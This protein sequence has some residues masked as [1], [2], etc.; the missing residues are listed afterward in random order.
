MPKDG[1]WLSV[2]WIAITACIGIAA[3]A[4]G[5]Q[6]WL[7]IECSRIERWM[8]VVCGLLLVYPAP[9]SDAIGLAGVAAVVTLQVLRRRRAI[10]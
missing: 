6:K 10:A 2:A 4:A 7:L 9:A 3:L 5:T 1:S 8:L